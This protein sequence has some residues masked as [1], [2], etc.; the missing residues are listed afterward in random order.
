RSLGRR[1][2]FWG[3]RPPPPERGHKREAPAYQDERFLRPSS[4]VR[5]NVQ[6]NKEAIPRHAKH[7]P[8]TQGI[9]KPHACPGF[10]IALRASGMTMSETARLR[11]A[12]LRRNASGVERL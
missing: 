10:R 11:P 3:L 9:T 8:G 12:R 4:G 2:L 1:R 7:E 5:S 6:A